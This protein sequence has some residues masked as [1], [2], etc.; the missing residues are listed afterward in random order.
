MK[1]EAAECRFSFP[2]GHRCWCRSPLPQTPET[3]RLPYCFPEWSRFAGQ[4]KKRSTA[5]TK[6][7]TEECLQ[8]SEKRPVPAGTHGMYFLS[9][10][11]RQTQKRP[12]NFRI[13]SLQLRSLQSSADEP[14][15]SQ[16]LFPVPLFRRRHVSVPDLLCGQPH[17]SDKHRRSCRSSARWR[18]SRH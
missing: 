10:K 9:E 12:Y 6:V 15:Q 16:L 4:M 11:K 8:G 18:V 3:A 1:A 5:E 17:T 2:V 7:P 14:F 13:S